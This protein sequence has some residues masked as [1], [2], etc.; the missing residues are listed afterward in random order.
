MRTPCSRT[1]GMLLC[2]IVAVAIIENPT[3][4]LAGQVIVQP[5]PSIAQDIWT[6]NSF[7]AKGV[8]DEKLWVGG[9]GDTY[10]TYIRFDLDNLPQHADS[11]FIQFYSYRGPHAGYSHIPMYMDRV[12][13]PWDYQRPDGF[14]PWSSKPQSVF[15]RMLDAPTDETWY[16]IDVTDLYNAWQAG[17]LS[18]YGIGLRPT[19]TYDQ[20][21]YFWSS[22]YTGNTALR[23]RL[24]VNTAATHTTLPAYTYDGVNGPQTIKDVRTGERNQF[25]FV[26]ATTNV[27][28]RCLVSWTTTFRNWFALIDFNADAVGTEI[29]DTTD[30]RQTFYRTTY[31]PAGVSPAESFDYPIGTGAPIPEQITP[32]R[33]DLYPSGATS[34]PLR[35]RASPT[36]DWRNVQDVGSYYAETNSAGVWMWEGLHPGEDWN[37]GSFNEDGGESVRC[38]ANGQVILIKPVA[39]SGVAASAGY[40]MVVRH[41]LLNGDSI[42]SLYVHIAPDRHAGSANSAGVI[43]AKGDFTYQEGSNVAKGSIIGVIGAVSSFY[44]H[45]H[46]ELRDKAID[47]TAPLWAHSTGDAYYGPEV[48][49]TGNRSRPMSKPDVEA[50]FRL[51]RADGIIDPS[52]FIDDHRP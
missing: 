9:W 35:E 30:A 43:G 15:L 36:A 46:F 1:S 11:A 33:N 47:P 31:L 24:V 41:W 5:G 51:M 39:E 23:P 48:G 22:R 44:S 7:D 45:L 42:D 8:T 17:T 13:Q 18:N 14:M 38:V 50:A 16:S 25:S 4:T 27:G 32:E 34:D 21:N 3:A 28:A 40:V 20:F 37:K 10:Y 49:Q 19:S 6:R 52:D 12:T 26:F 2:A 29:T